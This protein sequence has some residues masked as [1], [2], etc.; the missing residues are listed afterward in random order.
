[1]GND[2][3]Q[4]NYVVVGGGVGALNAVKG[5]LK[6]E[7]QASVVMI[8]DDRLPPYDLPALSKEFLKSEKGIDDI[9]YEGAESLRARGLD[10]RLNSRATKLDAER[11]ILTLEDG[12]EIAFHKCFLS[13]GAR[14]IHLP[15]PGSELPEVFY[16][17]TADDALRIVSAAKRGARAVI[18]GAG[19]IGL[20]AA[21]SLVIMGLD[22]TVVE[23]MTRVWPRF[24]D[25][26]LASFVQV[27]CE[28]HGITFRLD[29][30]VV[31]IRGQSHVE[32]VATASGKMLGADL[33]CV[34]V[35]IR[36]NIELAADAGLL[37]DNGIRVNQYMQT[38]NPDIYAGGD[39]ANYI[40]PISGRRR[41][42]EHWGHAEYSGQIAG[43]NMT[44]AEMAYDFVSYVWSDLFDLHL[45]AAGDEA[46]FDDLVVR[47][48]IDAGAFVML[49][50]K[51][52]KLVSYTAVNGNPKEF[53]PLRRLIRSA[54]D[55]R[56][57][58]A[59]LSDPQVNMRALVADTL[60]VSC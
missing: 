13:T 43:A 2:V 34:G 38:S 54:R 31:K 19:F 58:R 5:I 39:A 29:E 25:E 8:S 6:R 37:V 10:L 30:T 42:S 1:M 27:H 53:V 18:V 7:P 24:A 49:Y 45:E 26:I 12:E 57:K 55:I 51:E 41:R 50:L 11:R 23:A 16:L 22:V 60:S 17:R 46:H 20:E 48:S 14:P 36:P 40:D 15:V 47:G 52:G 9:V 4:A 56:D 59:Q 21:A 3:E 35:G 28:R 32:G 44:G 33:V